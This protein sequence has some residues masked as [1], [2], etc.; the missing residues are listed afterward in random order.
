MAG[1]HEPPSQATFYL[2]LAT[3]AL[4][5]L[6]VVGAIALG[7]FVLSKGFPTGDSA[8][9]STPPQEETTLTTDPTSPAPTDQPTRNV[10]QPL[11]ASE[12]TLQ[13]LNGTDQTGLAA[14][15]AEMLEEAGYQISTI[16]DAATS[17][18]VTTLFYK[19]KRKVDAQILQGQFFP[20][21]KLEVADED[22]K[23]DITVN[24]G[25]DYAASLEAEGGTEETPA[26]ES[27]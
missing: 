19:P 17:Y 22:V 4:R 20:S 11:D 26:D 8:P 25:D 23:V 27:T 10:P 5:G 24:I 1:R 12:I 21:A 9:A 15:T 18:P 14:E 6:L 16:G 7:L 2:S 13:V 3:A